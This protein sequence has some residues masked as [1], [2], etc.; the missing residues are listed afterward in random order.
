MGRVSAKARELIRAR[1]TPAASRAAST[2]IARCED[3]SQLLWK[4]VVWMGTSSVCPSMVT[5][6]AGSSRKRRAISAMAGRASLRT[7][8]E[9][10]SKRSAS[11]NS[12]PSPSASS[13]VRTRSRSS[14]ERSTIWSTF[15]RS[16][17][18]GAAWREPE[19]AAAIRS[20]L[21][22]RSG[23]E[24]MIRTKNPIS[25]VSRSA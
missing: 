10:E 25:S 8:A 1:S 22:R 11:L 19:R 9:P 17:S 6:R 24:A 13:R 15:S 2:L 4:G 21:A 14:G 18:S 3:S 7:S 23:T 16:R 5:G 20:K 12:I